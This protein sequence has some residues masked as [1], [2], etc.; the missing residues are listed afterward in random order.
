MP[1]TR[2]YAE[3]YSD[4]LR[5]AAAGFTRRAQVFKSNADFFRT[6]GNPE[7]VEHFESLAAIAALS[8]AE[9]LTLAEKGLTS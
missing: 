6:T 5:A 8:A 7:R 9:I 1:D 3:G 4:G 2:T